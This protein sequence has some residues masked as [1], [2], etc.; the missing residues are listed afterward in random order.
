MKGKE[1]ENGRP[2]GGRAL[3]WQTP[4]KDLKLPELFPLFVDG[5]REKSEPLSFFAEQGV[6]D[7]VTE[8]TVKSL[9]GA[10]RSIVYPLKDNLRTLDDAICIKTLRLIQ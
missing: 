5:L 4:I 10:I 3:I 8:S 6:Q 7:L 1:E 9:L 2:P